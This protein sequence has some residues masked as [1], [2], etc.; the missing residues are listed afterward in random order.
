VSNDVTGE[1]AA[2]GRSTTPLA[3]ADIVAA[4]QHAAVR[5]GDTV[6]V[7][8]S[9]SRLGWVVGSGPTIV[10]A[11]TEALGPSGTLVMP[12]QAG[13]S[14]PSNWSNPPV[15]EQWWPTIRA[16]WPAFD[17]FVSPLREMGV[18]AECFHRM[19]DVRH[20]GHPATG[21]IARGPLAE[22]IAASHPLED[23]LGERSPLG[24]LYEADARIVLV[25]VGHG[26]NTSLHLAEHRAEFPG[27]RRKTEGAPL[28]VDGERRWVTYTDLDYDDEDFVALGEAFAANGG[29]E[30]RVP[31]GAGYISTYSMRELVD[32]GTEWISR[33]RTR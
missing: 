6:I 33:S 28:M 7:H 9:I 19:L 31:C 25:G 27:K 5:A 13:I 16:N 10:A 24:R 14:D 1:A 17:P 2:V 21:F 30:H 22:V 26:N 23:G 8:C 11:L 29:S 32:F 4:L 12:A 15:P 3:T 20:S 18:V